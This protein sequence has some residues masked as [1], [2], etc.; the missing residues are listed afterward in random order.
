MLILGR[1][2]ARRAHA[3]DRRTEPTANGPA[4]APPAKSLGPLRKPRNT[5]TITPEPE[6]PCPLRKRTA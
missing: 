1:A 4:R 5:E 3:G 6:K 2:R